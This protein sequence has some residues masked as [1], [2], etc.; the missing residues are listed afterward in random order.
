MATTMR[1]VIREFVA[2]NERYVAGGLPLGSLERWGDLVEVVDGELARRDAERD[3]I[4]GR[5]L[6]TR[7][8]LRLPVRFFAASA[9]GMGETTDL[10]SAGCALEARCPLPPHADI[11][12]SVRLPWGLGTLRPAGQIRWTAPTGTSG[13][14]QAGVAFEPL[15]RWEREAIASCVLGAVAPRFIGLA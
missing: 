1:D 14:W 13:I 7:A 6:Y 3:G 2:L 8:P 11:Q 10:S 9:I 12:L 4:E 5:R 15:A